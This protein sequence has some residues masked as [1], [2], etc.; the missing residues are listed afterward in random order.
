MP[1]LPPTYRSLALLVLLTLVVATPLTAALA[2]GADASGTAVSL[3]TGD[4]IWRG[5][6]VTFDGSVAVRDATGRSVLTADEANRT[7]D[8]RRLRADGTPGDVATRITV[9]Q[10]GGGRLDT[11]ALDGRY[12]ITYGE[13]LV[14]VTDGRS[15]LGASADAPDASAYAWD[16]TDDAAD[17]DTAL[18][19]QNGTVVLRPTDRTSLSGHVDLPAG[20]EVLVRIAHRGTR[21][22]VVRVPTTVG[23]EGRLRTAVNLK[24]VRSGTPVN[25]SVLVGD[26]AL[27]VTEGVVLAAETPTSSPSPTST[28][29]RPTPVPTVSTSPG[30]GLLEGLLAV[31]CLVAAAARLTGQR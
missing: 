17:V 31:C 10:S 13:H 30:F 4:T 9:N 29:S 16:I 1:P 28:T 2:A 3:D 21:S 12:V 5:Q 14:D 26:D 19:R 8:V 25:V 15:T 24:Y 6:R 18:D 27:L 23:D 7:F 22:F 11:S 20:T